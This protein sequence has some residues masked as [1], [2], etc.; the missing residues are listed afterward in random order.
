[1]NLPHYE[2]ISVTWAI[3]FIFSM[4][5][6]KRSWDKI[7][8]FFFYN[9]ISLT[10]S[11]SCTCLIGTLKKTEYNLI[12]KVFRGFFNRQNSTFN[13]SDS[14]FS[15]EK[16]NLVTIVVGSFTAWIGVVTKNWLAQAKFLLHT[17]LLF[18]LFGLITGPSF[19]SISY[20]FWS[21]DSFLL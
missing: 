11:F 21:C 15:K 19:I 5:Q 14:F 18:L 7:M 9:Q 10:L 16:G 12:C 1:M 4:L 3:I 13:S 6:L 20:W 17:L 2:P 8:F